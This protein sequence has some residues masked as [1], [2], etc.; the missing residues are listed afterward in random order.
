MS[1]PIGDFLALPEFDPSFLALTRLSKRATKLDVARQT[2][3]MY[4]LYRADGLSLHRVG[5]L[6]N[7]T[8]EGVSLRFRRFGLPTRRHWGDPLRD[9]SPWNDPPDSPVPPKR[10]KEV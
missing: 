9:R 1:A 4:H 10:P 2:S 7:L 3:A 5:R 6:F 8:A